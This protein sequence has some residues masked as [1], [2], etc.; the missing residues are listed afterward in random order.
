MEKLFEKHRAHAMR[1][2]AIRPD[3]SDGYYLFIALISAFVISTLTIL[4]VLGFALI[5]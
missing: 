3:G 4:I 2:H 1:P 5:V